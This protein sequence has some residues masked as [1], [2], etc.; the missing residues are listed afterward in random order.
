MLIDAEMRTY[1][2]FKFHKKSDG[3][4]RNENNKDLSDKSDNLLSVIIDVKSAQLLYLYV[5]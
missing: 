2:L 1:L 5:L 3:I 4:E